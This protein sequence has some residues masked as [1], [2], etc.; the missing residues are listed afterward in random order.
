MES[1]NVYNNSEP[2]QEDNGNIKYPYTNYK[3]YEME[4]TRKQ[5]FNNLQVY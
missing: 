5:W 2:S 1:E 3:L 4:L